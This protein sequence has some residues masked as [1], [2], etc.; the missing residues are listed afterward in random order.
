MVLT[1]VR[2]T[3]RCCGFGRVQLSVNDVDLFTVKVLVVE[4]KLLD[5]DLL[6]GMDTIRVCIN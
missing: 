3:P 1:V 2:K 5:L 6:L 4:R